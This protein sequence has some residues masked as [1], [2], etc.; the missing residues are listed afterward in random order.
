MGAR[1]RRKLHFAVAALLYHTGAL[2]LWRFLRRAVLRKQETCVLGLH[3]VLTAAEQAR[4]N[5]VDGMVLSD[6]AFA[7]LLAYLRSNFDTVS[8][9]EFL[10]GN[11]GT[12]GRAKP[13]CLLTFDDGWGD[14]YYTAYPWLRKFNMPAVVFVATGSIGNRGGFWVEQLNGVLKIPAMRKRMEEVLNEVLEQ[15]GT[16]PCATDV[17]EWLKHMPAEKRNSILKK[18]LPSPSSGDAPLL[19]DEVDSMMTWDQT[20]E[21]NGDGIEIGAHTVTH[22]LLSHEDDAT[23]ERELRLSKETLEKRLGSRV[24]ALAYPNGDWD[25]RIRELAAQTG[26]ECAF[27]TRPGWHVPGQD[28]YAIRRILLHDGNVVGLDGQ[29]SPAMLNLTL[30]RGT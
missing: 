28:P 6:A 20:A 11:E 14:T 3:R 2:T 1:L 7:K 22:L 21:M 18:L 12:G 23:A 26:Y 8:L 5:S 10:S 4:T 27:T 19:F 25:E 30:A 29:F 15:G 9:K 24:R 13:R 16:R 17:I